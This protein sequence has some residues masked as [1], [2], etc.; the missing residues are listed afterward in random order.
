MCLQTWQVNLVVI[1]PNST[2]SNPILLC[3]PL[4]V[5]NIFE[6][7]VLCS[8][9]LSSNP[10][11]VFGSLSNLYQDQSSCQM[12]TI[13]AIW[14]WWYFQQLWNFSQYVSFPKAEHSLQPDAM[15]LEYAC[16][17]HCFALIFSPGV[18]L[19]SSQGSSNLLSFRQWQWQCHQK[20]VIP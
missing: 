16:F 7:C 12:I 20:V 5:L 14:S 18:R 1:W 11:M 15:H 19:L 9:C 3:H 2:Q 10:Y 17:C 13:L 6:G 4:N 8:F